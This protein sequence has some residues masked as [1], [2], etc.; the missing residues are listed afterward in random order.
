MGYRST[1]ISQDWPCNEL[2]DW[3]KDKYKRYLHYPQGLMISSLFEFKIYDN[4][5]FEDYQKAV[6]ESGFWDKSDLKVK[7]VVMAEDGFVSQV[8]ISKD[9]IK[10]LWLTFDAETEE[11]HVW[12]QG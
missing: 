1:L 9:D 11:D 5:I 10:Y 4:E 12:C 3:F 6:K 2:P 8:I 7:V